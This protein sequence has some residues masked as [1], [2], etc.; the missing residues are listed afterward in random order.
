[1]SMR[2][3]LDSFDQAMMLGFLT[4]ARRYGDQEMFEWSGVMRGRLLDEMKKQEALL[5]DTQML[6]MIE[7]KEPAEKVAPTVTKKPVGKR[8]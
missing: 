6:K 1:M 3:D 5:V 7:D 8:P 4:L 2:L